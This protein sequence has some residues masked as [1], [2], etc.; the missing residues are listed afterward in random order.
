MPISFLFTERGFHGVDI[1]VLGEKNNLF[2]IYCSVNKILY[3][4]VKRKKKGS[5]VKLTFYDIRYFCFQVM[6]YLIIYY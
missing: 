6:I 5:S 1:L 2:H 4:L 3:Y